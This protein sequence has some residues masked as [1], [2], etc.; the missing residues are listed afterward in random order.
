MFITKTLLMSINS[1]LSLIKTFVD[2]LSILK[3]LSTTSLN[4]ILKILTFLFNRPKFTGE[5]Q[6]ENT[7]LNTI[8]FS[9]LIFVFSIKFK[10]SVSML[11]LFE[12]NF[13]NNFHKK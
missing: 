8:Q 7:L 2:I 12:N 9:D 5:Y 6:I 4:I 3:P 13:N 10:F 1:V 11:I